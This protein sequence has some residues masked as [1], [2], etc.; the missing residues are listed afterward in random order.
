MRAYLLY[1]WT[2]LYKCTVHLASE[3]KC[4]AMDQQS[5]CRCFACPVDK[6]VLPPLRMASALFAVSLAFRI[7]STSHSLCTAQLLRITCSPPHRNCFDP[8]GFKTQ[9]QRSTSTVPLLYFWTLSAAHWNTICTY[10]NSTLQ[11]ILQM[12]CAQYSTAPPH[13]KTQY[14]VQY[15]AHCLRSTQHY[16]MCSTSTIAHN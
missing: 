6:A 13:R 3:K 11:Y 2:I 12:Y 14:W 9:T 5:S 15:C 16:Y 1:E 8:L 10:S 7:D 4:N